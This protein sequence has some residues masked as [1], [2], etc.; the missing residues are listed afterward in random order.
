MAATKAVRAVVVMRTPWN[1]G[2]TADTRVTARMAAAGKTAPKIARR[3]PMIVAA[4]TAMIPSTMTVEPM[5]AASS[6]TNSWA[7]YISGYNLRRKREKHFTRA[8]GAGIGGLELGLEMRRV[9]RFRIGGPHAQRRLESYGGR[10]AADKAG[11][12][13]A[14][15]TEMM[16]M[17]TTSSISVNALRGFLTSVAPRSTT[18]RH[19]FSGNFPD[20]WLFIGRGF[21]GNHAPPAF[22]TGYGNVTAVL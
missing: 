1:R 20:G 9:D 8:G 14:A 22:A 13:K 15:S 4:R 11:S 21:F 6:G 12:S 18:L 19:D 10:E 7:K 16:T 2:W 5:I 3:I 17:T